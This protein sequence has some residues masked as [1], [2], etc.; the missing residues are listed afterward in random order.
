MSINMSYIKFENTLAALQ[1][2]AEDWYEAS[3]ESEVKAKKKLVA[4]MAELLKD[5]GFEV[6]DPR[7]PCTQVEKSV[8]DG[9][10]CKG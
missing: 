5:E 7:C 3:N 9:T 2:C 10:F 6:E 4:L 1:E 8:C